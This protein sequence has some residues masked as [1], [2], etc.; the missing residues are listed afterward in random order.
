MENKRVLIPSMR[1]H[2]TN[3]LVVVYFDVLNAKNN[4]I[5][6]SDNSINFDVESDNNRY[7]VVLEL[8]GSINPDESEFEIDEKS[9]KFMLKKE[10]EH[11]T[12]NSLLKDKNMYKNN[13]KTNW[14]NW[15]DSDD[16]EED[17]RGQPLMN[18]FD[19]GMGGGN[20][21]FDFKQMMANM[22]GMAGMNGMPDMSDIP[23]MSEMMKNINFG[24][25]EI[26][27]DADN[28]DNDEQDEQD[29]NNEYDENIC[30][31]CT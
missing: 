25:T 13:I 30:Q 6:L 23:D 14:Q 8:F 3:E 24:D 12:W 26:D 18:P 16:E 10:T 20:Q 11:M 31:E 22:G 17:T 29:E 9:V 21:Q 4:D 5:Y 28:E 7:Y 1:W 19:F 27:L 15:V 2:Q